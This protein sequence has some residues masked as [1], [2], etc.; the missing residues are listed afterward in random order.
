[1]F[2]LR[3]KQTLTT[4]NAYPLSTQHLS[5]GFTTSLPQ[6]KK[7]IHSTLSRYSRYATTDLPQS[8]STAKTTT[9][10]TIIPGQGKHIWSCRDPE[11]P[12]ITGWTKTPYKFK[13]AEEYKVVKT[14]QDLTLPFEIRKVATG[15]KLFYSF[16]K[17]NLTFLLQTY[18]LGC[19]VTSSNNH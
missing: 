14:P 19:F 1:M 16:T 7:I 4:D 18:P 15:E 8:T 12:Q 3:T 11:Q 17:E 9:Q 13:G 6:E 2:H 5:C 10:S